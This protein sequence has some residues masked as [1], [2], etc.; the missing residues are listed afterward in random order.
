MRYIDVDQAQFTFAGP[1]EKSIEG[2]RRS[3][4]RS[5]I[6]SIVLRV[7]AARHRGDIE[8][9]DLQSSRLAHQTEENVDALY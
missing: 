7:S 2:E 8:V 1:G 9:F 5:D 3:R 6:R 4:D